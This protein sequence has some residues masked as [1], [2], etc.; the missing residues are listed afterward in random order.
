MPATKTAPE[1]VTY[2]RNQLISSILRIGHGDL[3][4]FTNVGMQASKEDP[5][6]FAHL[7]AWNAING[8][9]FDA[10]VALPPLALRGLTKKDADLAEN[11]VAHML[12]L[13]P[14][15]LIRSYN[16][17][18]DLT[19][20]GHS[21]SGGYRRLLEQGFQRYLSER[22]KST[23]WWD[24]VVLQH[25]KSMLR[26]YYISHKKPT[27]RAQRILF[28]EEFPKNS[29]FALMRELPNM[30]PQEA[31]GTIIEKDLPFEVVASLKNKSREII[32][33]LL[34]VATG[35]QVITNTAMFK[36]L[37]VFED[38]ALKAA[39]QAALKRAET[40]TKVHTLKAGRAAKALEGTGVAEQLNRLQETKISQSAGIEGDWLVLGDRSGSM[41]SCI[42]LAR[43]IAGFVSRQVKGSVYLVFFDNAPTYFDVTGKTYDEILQV[44]SRVNPRG[45]TS[46]GCGLDYIRSRKLVVNGIAVATDGGENATPWFADVYKK[47]CAEM[48]VEPTVYEFL[49]GGYGSSAFKSKCEGAGISV[50]QFKLGVQVDYYSLP[51]IVSTM[52][53]NRYELFDNVMETPLLTIDEVYER[54]TKHA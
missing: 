8:K 39:Y 9:I 16:Y 7:I 20:A 14:R 48:Q 52:K 22:E 42:E 15:H 12:K 23:R 18:R 1:Q 17:S 21:I 31:A 3:T 10:K 4:G 51:N 29:V 53:T 49:V 41:S 5:E 32:L 40:D 11:A 34:E 43:Q 36:K 26:L 28:D 47:Y 27:P 38:P 37:G 45:S 13:D 25:R 6:L 33:A 2:T 46:M 54:R 24:S 35:N 19:R 30:T 50:E 44:T